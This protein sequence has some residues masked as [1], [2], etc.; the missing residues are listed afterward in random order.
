[1]TIRTR[2]PV[3]LSADRTDLELVTADGPRLVDEPA[4]PEQREPLAT[5]I[6]PHPLPLSTDWED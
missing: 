2:G 3:L 4:V 1:M 6:T 5:L